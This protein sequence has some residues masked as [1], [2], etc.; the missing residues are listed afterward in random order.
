MKVTVGELKKLG[1]DGKITSDILINALAKG[2]DLNKDKIQQLLDE[3]PAQKFKAFGN[4]VS[5]LSNAVGTELL[6]VVTPAVVELT[7]LL[8]AVS[9]LPK[10]IREV[11][12]AILLLT[13]AAVALTPAIKGIGAA[14]AGITGA[15]L[16]AAAPWL[17]LAAGITAAVVA[18]NRYNAAKEPTAQN[19]KRVG[20][21]LLKTDE[22]IE[23][24]EA[25]L[26][27]ATKDRDRRSANVARSDL[28]FF[29][30]QRLR[31]LKEFNKLNALVPLST[32]IQTEDKTLPKVIAD[33]GKGGAARGP[34]DISTAMETL[35]LR[36]QQLRFSN[37]QLAQSRIEKEI[38]I[39]GILESQA[40]P[41]QQ[42]IAL[43]EAENDALFRT[44][45][46]FAENFK[47]ADD[48]N[49]KITASAIEGVRAGFAA[50]QEIDAEL[51][52]QA[53]KMNQLYSSIGQ[54]I[55]TGIVDSL[56]AA[57]DGT[58]SL[59]EVASNTLRSLANIMLKFGLQTF[60]GG[61]GGG[62]PGSIFTKLFGGGKASGGSVSSSKSYLVGERG[63]ELFTPGRSGSIAPNGATGGVNVG[64]INIQV[65]NTGEQ[66]TP[67]AQKQLAGQVQGIVLSTLANERRSGGML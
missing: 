50:A 3:S 19:L 40:Q 2:F 18:L 17:A 12:A 39:Q 47:K 22:A 1:S 48:A 53:E 30:D 63:P 9:Q 61:L 31:K 24:V 11:G 8:K 65:E 4:A 43:I 58:K 67:A 56:T 15:G 23:A 33:T 62:D 36:Q 32:P 57:V 20:A 52:A 10:P 14:L 5:E 55:T 7:K 16:L 26:A 41:R 6:P 34:Q 60:L 54:T 38:Q 21:E 37:D 66:L 45:S 27:K 35:L 59:A 42:N 44:A 13:T 29:Q 64:T 51:Q 28:K 49:K 25:R 46:I